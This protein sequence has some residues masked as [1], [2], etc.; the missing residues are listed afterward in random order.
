M[1]ETDKKVVKMEP[2]ESKVTNPEKMSYE[3]LE[4]VAHQLSEQSRQ[5]YAKLQEVNLSNIFKRLDYLFKVVENGN[6]FSPDFLNHCIAEIEGLLTISEESGQ[7]NND[8]E[9][10]PDKEAE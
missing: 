2:T 9:E 7:T 4:N 3:E 8:E 6:M 5:L 10:V 1:E